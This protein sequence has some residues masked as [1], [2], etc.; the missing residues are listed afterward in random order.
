MLA[1]LGLVIAVKKCGYHKVGLL[2]LPILFNFITALLIAGRERYR[3]P[4]D[5]YLIL[6]SAYSLVSL[7]TYLKLALKRYQ[8]NWPLK[9]RE[10]A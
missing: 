5:P 3:L 2:S 9:E 10:A 4:I 1:I 6:F 8:G 7:V